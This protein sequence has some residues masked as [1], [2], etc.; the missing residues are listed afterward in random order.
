MKQKVIAIVG[1]TAVGKSSLGIDIAKKYNGEI[2]SG[3]SMQI[4]KDFDI[5]TAKVSTKEMDGVTHHLIDTL[6]PTESYSAANFQK[7]ARSLIKEISYRG[8]LPIIVGGTGLYI[9]AALYNY[10]FTEEKR[11][12]LFEEKLSKEIETDG[13][14]KVYKRLERIDPEQAKKIHPNNVRRVIRALEI[15]EHSGDKMSDRHEK[16]LTPLYDVHIIGLQMERSRLYDRINKRVDLMIEQGLISEVK[17]LLEK[18]YRELQ[19][20]GAIG[21]KEIVAYIDNQ[22]SFDTAIELLKRNSRRF[23][24]RQFTWFRNKMHINWYNVEEDKD[25]EYLENILNDLEGFLQST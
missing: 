18:G 3:D 24:K 4:Y 7:E 14:D 13:I 22:N 11:N 6:E 21:Y 2:I 9:Q 12:T 8:K 5:G 25:L 23:A 19:P 15:Y 1:P 17:A 10:K 20:M 16:A